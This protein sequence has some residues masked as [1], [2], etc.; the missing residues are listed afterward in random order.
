MRSEVSEK[1][2]FRGKKRILKA[3]FFGKHRV[4]RERKK[5]RRR[6]VEVEKKVGTA[7]GQKR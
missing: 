2:V 6:K 3:L 7:L 4:V 5:E 1:G